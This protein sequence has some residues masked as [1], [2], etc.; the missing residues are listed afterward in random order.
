MMSPPTPRSR[1]VLT[2]AFEL[3]GL[4]IQVVAL[5]PD[6]HHLGGL[7]FQAQARESFVHPL[8]GRLRQRAPQIDC[9]PRLCRRRSAGDRCATQIDDCQPEQ[10]PCGDRSE[11]SSTY[12][13]HSLIPSQYRVLC[14]LESYSTVFATSR[15]S[16]Q[17]PTSRAVSR[18]IRPSTAG[19]ITRNDA[20]CRWRKAGGVV[21][22]RP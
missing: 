21:F 18:S 15:P 9:R 7:L 14:T 19:E 17:T 11:A 16:I 1:T 13:R 12:S 20:G 10:C 2:S 3:L 22:G 5:D 6:H 8:L 4:R